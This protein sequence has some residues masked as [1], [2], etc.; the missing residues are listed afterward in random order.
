MKAEEFFKNL[1]RAV[2][3]AWQDISV[4]QGKRLAEKFRD[5]LIRNVKSQAYPMKPL[6]PEYAAFKRANGLDSRIL[7]ASGKYLNEK[8]LEIK[9]EIG[10]S[11]SDGPGS[12]LEARQ[13]RY[14]VK[15][16]SKMVEPSKTRGFSLKSAMKTPITYEKLAKIHEYGSASARI[17]ARPHWAATAKEFNSHA[18]EE[19]QKLQKEFNKRVSEL[20]QDYLKRS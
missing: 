8:T 4:E 3:E 20:V 15:P 9:K 16:S 2:A 19:N 18:A 11:E 17:P 10:V 14:T 1:E 7:I 13:V 6:N 5:T 12:G